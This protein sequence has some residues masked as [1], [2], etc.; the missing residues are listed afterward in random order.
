MSGTLE[1]TERLY[2]IGFIRESKNLYKECNAA[3]TNTP[4][5]LM[6]IVVSARIDKLV[7]TAENTN[8]NQNSKTAVLLLWNPFTG[9]P[10]NQR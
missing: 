2:I 9:K 6:H 5:F 3:W 10:P 4:Q 8:I 1:D 7:K